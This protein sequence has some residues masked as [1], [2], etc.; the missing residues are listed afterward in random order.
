MENVVSLCTKT[1]IN[2]H[3]KFGGEGVLDEYMID[4]TE[5]EVSDSDYVSICI[6]NAKQ[7]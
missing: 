7:V 4:V 6:R 5:M 2:L 3:E 1:N